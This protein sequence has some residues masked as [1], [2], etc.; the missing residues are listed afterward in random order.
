MS[1]LI[2]IKCDWQGLEN[3]EDSFT[4]DIVTDMTADLEHVL[5]LSHILLLC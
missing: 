4:S 1:D 5:L 2:T 3:P